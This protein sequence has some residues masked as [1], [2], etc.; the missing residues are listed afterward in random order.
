MQQSERIRTLSLLM[1]PLNDRACIFEDEFIMADSFDR[2]ERPDDI[3][4]KPEIQSFVAS[5]YPFKIEFTMVLF[6]LGGSIRVRSNLMEYELQ[7]N[8]IFFL[9]QGSIGQ[10]L[11]ISADCRMVFIAFSKGYLAM[12][13]NSQGAAIIRKFLVRHSVLRVSESDMEEQMQIYRALRRKIEQPDYLYK[14]KEVI[15]GYMRVLAYNLC[16]L[17]TPYVEVREEHVGN[18]KKKIYDDFMDLVH[19]YYTE[20]RNIGFYADKLCIT[21][22][23]LSQMVYAVSGRHAGDWIRDYVILEAKALLKSRQYTIQQISDMLNFAN[24]SFFGV[25]FKKEVGC[26][27]KAYQNA[28]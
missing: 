27:P 7:K 24:Q 1:I 11:D 23:Y 18:R 20:E 15:T 3:F 17:I 2:E 10:C 6:C 13:S 21:P 28:K 16:Q 4:S 14:K 22:K 5:P 9:Q 8:D 26:S 12:E 19:E 25:Y